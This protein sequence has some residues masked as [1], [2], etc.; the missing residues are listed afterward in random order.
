MNVAVN[1]IIRSYGSKSV[2]QA[3]DEALDQYR[4]SG[5]FSGRE[6]TV[7][8]VRSFALE[9]RLTLRQAVKLL[10]EAKETSQPPILW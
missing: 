6:E 10:W 7:A 9:F 2:D 1:N 4:R 8:V 5:A 3:I